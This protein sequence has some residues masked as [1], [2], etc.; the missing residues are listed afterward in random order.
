MPDRID[1]DRFEPAFAQLA[2]ILRRQIAGGVYPPGG[3]I[4]S[5]SSISRQ[6]GLSV[7]TVRQAIGVLT[8]QGLIERIQGSGTFVKPVTLTGSRFDLDSIKEIF[9]D[10]ERTRVKVL[11]ISLAWTDAK[12]AQMLSLPIGV[13]II[14]I[15]RLLLRD[16]RPVMS[17]EGRIRCDP[18]RPLV[19]AE[20]GLGPLSDLFN[21]FGGGVAKK[22]ELT[23]IP[24]VLNEEEAGLLNQ[25]VGTPVFRLEY[26]VYDF[27]DTPFGWGWFTVAP[28]T[29]TLKTKLG[30]W[31]EF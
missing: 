13:R 26:L 12:T 7:M 24:T 14:L 15:R 28:E 27:H 1:K 19:E 4:P 8:E 21:W 10:Q 17:H 11:Q 29:L 6:Y 9:Q 23:V 2:A 20:L 5:E 22:G 16:N 25:R 3:K 31:D 30:S 18:T